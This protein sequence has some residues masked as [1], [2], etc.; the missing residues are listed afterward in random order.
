M[1]EA[2]AEVNR[3]AKREYIAKM[4]T[5]IFLR[6]TYLIIPYF[7]SY[8]VQAITNGNHNRAYFLA[9][10]LLAFTIAYYLSCIINDYFFEKLYQKVYTGLTKVCLQYTEK[11]SIYSLSRIPLGEYNSIMTDDINVIADYYGNLPMAIARLLDF[12]IVFFYFFTANFFV[13]LLSVTI[14]I[15]VLIYLYFGNRKVNIIN[16]QDKA[17]HSQ[18]LGV[19][20]EYF[21][22]MK[23]VKGFRLF[24]KVHK[25]IEKNYAH[26]LNWH[27]KYGLWKV[28]ITNTA[29]GAVEIIK[30]FILFYGFYLATKGKISLA[31]ILLVYSYFD[32]LI[33]NYTGLLDF[34]DR[35]Q[36][37]KVSKARM[38]KL[39]EFS[40]DSKNREN[41]KIIKKGVVD[42]EDVLYGNRKDPIL[43]HFS[44]HIPSRSITVVTGKTGAG[45]TG[46]I[47]LLLRL[48]RQHEGR[49]TI[50]KIDI[51]DYADDLYFESVSAVRKNPTFFHMSIRD[52][53][54]LIEPDFEKIVNVCKELGVHDDIMKLNDGY[55]TVISES[56]ANINNDLKYML[57]IARV[58]LKNPQVLLFDETLSAF[59]KEV[60]LKLIDYFKKTKG[61]HNVVLISKEKHVL[62][63]ADQVIYME[64]GENVASGK[65]ETLLLK[66]AKYK[67]YFDEL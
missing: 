1:K 38:L 9:G 16:N 54:T 34:N 22:G 17:T 62:E 61:K 13:G 48:N 32:R 18:R 42:F 31:V 36:N 21:F 40:H 15:A 67:K 45:K 63:E 6:L 12:I 44:C 60:D 53:L 49:I 47:D 24:G 7:Y 55:D 66:S 43:N 35:L 64:K 27:T 5:S 4:I 46:I 56:A 65:H 59:P 51:T 10:L 14:S 39:E 30:I 8:S 37:A 2:I 52:N 23:E 26:Y 19:L 3:S 50:D 20:Q 29:L 25:R 57:S 28:I 11:N 41:D 33:S 58:I